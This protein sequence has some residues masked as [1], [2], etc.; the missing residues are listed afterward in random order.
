MDAGGSSILFMPAALK[1]QFVIVL[2]PFGSNKEISKK[3]NAVTFIFDSP[4]HS[5]IF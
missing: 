2:S 3:T 5:L 4:N 1:M